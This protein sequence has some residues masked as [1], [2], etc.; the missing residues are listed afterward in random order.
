MK[1]DQNSPPALLVD[2]TTSLYEL[3]QEAHSVAPRHFSRIQVS[4][5]EFS[6]SENARW[7]QTLNQD[8]LACGCV[9]A[10]VAAST[11]VV[12]YWLWLAQGENLGW[13]AVIVTIFG[14]LLVGAMGKGVGKQLAKARMRKAVLHLRN[15]LER[16]FW[17]EGHGDSTPTCG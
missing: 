2:T 16:P 5:A 8:Y 9:E 7:S 3:Y 6:E 17:P 4:F 14:F 10:M 11:F 15:Q 1:M 13:E 12:S